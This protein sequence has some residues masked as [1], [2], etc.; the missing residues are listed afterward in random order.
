MSEDSLRFVA[1]QYTQNR[2]SEVEKKN[3]FSASLS[4]WKNDKANAEFAI[5]CGEQD[6]E[7][8]T[9]IVQISI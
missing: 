4:A 5:I 9:N 6:L 8:V 1:V 2:Y 7:N 3:V